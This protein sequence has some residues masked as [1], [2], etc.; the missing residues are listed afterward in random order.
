MEHPSHIPTGSQ[1]LITYI[2]PRDAALAIEWYGE[3]FGAEESTERFVDPDGRVGHAQIQIGQ[4]DIMVSDAYPDFGAVAPE[5][6]NVTATFALNLY[7]PDADATMAKAAA[8]GATIQ[9]PVEEQ[10]YGARMGTMIDPF[11]VRWM[12][13]THVRD[14]SPKEMSAAVDDFAESGQARSIRPD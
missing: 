12:I 14:V 6:G 13:G 8:A 5:P 1:E 11:G 7:V 2:C 3:V 10:F 9:R 4:A